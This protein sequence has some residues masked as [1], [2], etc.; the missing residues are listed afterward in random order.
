VNRTITFYGS[1]FIADQFGAKVPEL[2]ETEQG[3]LVQQLTLISWAHTQRL[4]RVSRSSA[5]PV[6]LDQDARWFARS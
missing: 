1:P 2:N 4:G 5:R 3:M 6:R